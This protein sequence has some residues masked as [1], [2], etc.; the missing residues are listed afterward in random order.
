MISLHIDDGLIHR[1]F[2]AVLAGGGTLALNHIS[3]IGIIH[4]KCVSTTI[5]FH[6]KY[7]LTDCDLCLQKMNGKFKPNIPDDLISFI[8]YN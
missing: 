5:N 6:R 2:G 8:V 1:F 4:K 7:L 3:N